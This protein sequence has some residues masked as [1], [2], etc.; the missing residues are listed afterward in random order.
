MTG[1]A[2]RAGRSCC[3]GSRR[4]TGTA[5]VGTLVGF[6]IVLIL[7]LLAVQVVLRMFA[8]SALSGAATRAA[9]AVAS[10]P[11]PASAVPVAEADARRS[12]G[13]YGSRRTVF[14]W[15][16][17]DG[18]QVTVMIRAPEPRVLPII[19]GWGWITRTVTVRTE[20]FR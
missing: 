6:A 10:S 11:D 3:H 12:L 15:E 8:T 14:V 19:P 1:E 2:G 16:E 9:E 20:R 4:D 7:L 17:V 5:V 18:S 13:S